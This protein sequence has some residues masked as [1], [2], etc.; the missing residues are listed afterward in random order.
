MSIIISA[1]LIIFLF[2]LLYRYLAV[3]RQEEENSMIALHL[4][5]G[6]AYYSALSKQA[7]AIRQYRHD[8]AG[9]IRALEYLINNGQHEDLMP[10]LQKLQ[11][12]HKSVS[13]TAFSNNEVVNALISGYAD[14]CR[15]KDISFSIDISGPLGEEHNI[16]DL[17]LLSGSYVSDKS[18]AQDGLRITDFC[19]LLNNLLENAVEECDRIAASAKEEQKERQIS[20]SIS[21][22]EKEICLI[23][24][25]SIRKNHQLT[26]ET[27][28]RHPEMHG[29][30]NAIIH[31]IIDENGGTVKDTV[32]PDE[33]LSREVSIPFCSN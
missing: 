25:N 31:R 16:I 22:T 21:Q 9:H 26:F 4:E 27:G 15:Q 29:I 3:Q 8:L 32:L 19:A 17:S 2:L 30:G 10:Y 1:I 18:E 6:Q 12:Q 20:L 33:S 11:E 14:T 28:K 23:V 5:T 24:T 7:E 13:V